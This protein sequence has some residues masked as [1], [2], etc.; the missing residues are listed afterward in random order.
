MLCIDNNVE[1]IIIFFPAAKRRYE[2]F[3]NI[4]LSSLFSMK[5]GFGK[6]HK[7]ISREETANTKIFTG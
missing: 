7:N 1:L 5:N 3:Q 4:A 2:P 6:V